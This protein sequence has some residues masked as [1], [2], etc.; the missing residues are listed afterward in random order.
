MKLKSLLFVCA[1]TCVLC[2]DAAPLAPHG[3]LSID[4]PGA[5]FRA[6]RKTRINVVPDGLSVRGEAYSQVTLSAL[7]RLPD[8]AMAERRA[9]RLTVHFKTSR[10]GPALRQIILPNGGTINLNL[11]GDFRGDAKRNTVDFGGAPINIYNDRDIQLVV[12]FPGGIDSQIDPGEFLLKGITV[13]YLRKP[14]ALTKAFSPL[15]R[16]R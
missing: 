14:Q 12:S 7:P 13:G 11:S 3:I 6:L 5:Q 2:T 16:S 10:N 15:V 1:L 4:T 9:S 8:A